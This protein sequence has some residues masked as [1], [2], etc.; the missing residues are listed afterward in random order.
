MP[1][2]KVIPSEIPIIPGILSSLPS[3]RYS[4]TNFVIPAGSP[5]KQIDADIVTTISPI[6]KTPN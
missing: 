3:E 6:E 1:N 5:T 4:L 2:A